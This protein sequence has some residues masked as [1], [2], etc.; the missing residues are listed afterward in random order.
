MNSG[1]VAGYN[2]NIQKPTALLY[3]NNEVVERGIRKTIPF[4]ITPKLIKYLGRNLT[5]E[6]KDL[7]SENYK[8]LMKDIEDDKEIE[9]FHDYRLEEQILLKCLYYQRNLHI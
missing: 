5:M 6:V 7:Y 3:S 9:T 1:K 4:T 8:T 2:I